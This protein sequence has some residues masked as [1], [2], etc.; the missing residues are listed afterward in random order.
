[1]NVAADHDRRRRRRDADAAVWTWGRRQRERLARWVRRSTVANIFLDPPPRPSWRL[2]LEAHQ[3]V[4][5]LF[6]AVLLLLLGLSVG[7]W[8]ATAWRYLTGG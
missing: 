3:S 6:T 1:V 5:F 2:F 7:D 8:L 4:T